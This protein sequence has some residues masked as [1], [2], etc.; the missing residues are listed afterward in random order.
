MHSIR[1]FLLESKS[2]KAEQQFDVTN[3][4]D[5]KKKMK[6]ISLK[7][8]K[9]RTVQVIFGR[10]FVNVYD[11]PSKIPHYAVGDTG[12]AL[13]PELK[14]YWQNGVLKPFSEKLVIKHQNIDYGPGD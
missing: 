1:E 14:G 6:E 5:L 3:S 4:D 8:N 2:K 10:A 9:V 7:D 11:S 13:H 12:G